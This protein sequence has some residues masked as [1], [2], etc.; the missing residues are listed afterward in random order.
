MIKRSFSLFCCNLR[1]NISRIDYFFFSQNWP[2]I[3]F[4]CLFVD[5][6]VAISGCRDAAAQ[7]ALQ[8]L[9][10]RQSDAASRVPRWRSQLATGR[11]R[12]P[13]RRC[14]RRWLR[15]T[16]Q[17]TSEIR[18]YRGESSIQFSSFFFFFICFGP[19]ILFSPISLPSTVLDYDKAQSKQRTDALE[20]YPYATMS[21]VQVNLVIWRGLFFKYKSSIKQSHRIE[22]IE[23]VTRSSRVASSSLFSIWF[24]FISRSCSP[25]PFFHLCYFISCY[26][27]SLRI[28][29]RSDRVCWCHSE[30]FYPPL[31]LSLSLSLALFD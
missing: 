19:C 3:C 28:F 1:C 18:P 22:C 4:V 16:S 23:L 31:L 27:L 13:S 25:A 2:L 10:E 30:L 8:S 14:S 6:G 9:R 20:W 12:C 5:E 7:L 17:Q 24:D 29:C 15:S 26:F 21:F 11:C